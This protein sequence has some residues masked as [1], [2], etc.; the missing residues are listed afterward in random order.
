MLELQ[1][2]LRSIELFAIRRGYSDG[3]LENDWSIGR[4]TLLISPWLDR[5]NLLLRMEFVGKQ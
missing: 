4:S 1:S 3:P 2:D 5:I